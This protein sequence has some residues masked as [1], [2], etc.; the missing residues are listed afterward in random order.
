MPRPT[1]RDS[2]SV[3]A[4]SGIV[5]LRALLPLC[6]SKVCVTNLIIVLVVGVEIFYLLL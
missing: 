5:S 6:I 4:I 2:K 3:C 1:L